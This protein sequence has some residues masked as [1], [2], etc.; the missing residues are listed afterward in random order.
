MTLLASGRQIA[1]NTTEVS[2]AIRCSDGCFSGAG[3]GGGGVPGGQ[4]GYIVVYVAGKITQY[5]TVNTEGG[6]GGPSGAAGTQTNGN[7]TPSAKSQSGKS[8]EVYWYPV[9]TSDVVNKAN[10][11]KKKARRR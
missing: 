8:G 2:C 4:G 9:K 11:K 7:A 1:P 10:I 5:P 6:K 3:A